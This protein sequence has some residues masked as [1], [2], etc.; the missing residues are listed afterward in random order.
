MWYLINDGYL[1]FTP[2]LKLKCDTPGVDSFDKS[3]QVIGVV[4]FHFH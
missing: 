2:L 4:Y 3:H 1:V